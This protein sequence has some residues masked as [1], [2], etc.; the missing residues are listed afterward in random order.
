MCSLASNSLWVR[1]DRGHDE[2]AVDDDRPAALELDQGTGR[3]RREVRTSAVLSLC[4]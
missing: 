1:L 3:A 2:R 4:S